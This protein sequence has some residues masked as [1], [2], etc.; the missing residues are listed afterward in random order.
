MGYG[1]GWRIPGKLPLGKGKLSGTPAGDNWLVPSLSA[2]P[3]ALLRAF[4]TMPT[5]APAAR[6]HLVRHGDVAAPWD[7]RIYGSMD[8]PLSKLGQQQSRGLARALEARP[9]AAVVSSGLSR[10]DFLARLVARQAGLEIRVEDRLKELDRGDWAGWDQEQVDSAD[11]GAWGRFWASGGVFDVPG[12][13]PLA[14]LQTRVVS[15]LEDLAGEFGGQE[16]LVV[17]HKWVLRA[18]LCTVLG[19]PME[20]SPRLHVPHL[21]KVSLD[22]AVGGGRRLV[23]LSWEPLGG[24]LGGSGVSRS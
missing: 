17:A 10:S 3:C 9:L 20:H 22:W 1:V 24:W 23:C 11:P 7:E 8:V 21:G 4:A 12:G 15:A 5:P 18:A 16:I 13:E 6:I 14:Q 19:M 2:R